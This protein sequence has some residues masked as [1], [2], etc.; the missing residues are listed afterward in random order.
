MVRAGGVRF[1][2]AAETVR[3]VIRT[4]ELWPV[5][6][7]EPQLLGLIQYGGEPLAVLDLATLAAT[8]TDGSP[9]RE[10]VVVLNPAKGLHLG[11]AVE[12]AEQ[13]V[14]LEGH[15]P[16]GGEGAAAGEGLADVRILEVQGLLNEEGRRGR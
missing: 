8:T 1:G 14:A 16:G 5:P 13:V 11:L 15:P 7:A 4:P 6:G 9:A 10:V 3:R 2:L 12:D